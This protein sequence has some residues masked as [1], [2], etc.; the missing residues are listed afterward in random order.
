M[1]PILAD[2]NPYLMDSFMLRLMMQKDPRIKRITSDA[3][4]EKKYSAIIF[5]KDPQSSSEWYSNSH[6]GREFVDMVLRNYRFSFKQD[7]YTVYVPI[8]SNAE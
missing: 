7:R 5:D 8:S 6:F 1:L 4:T 3:I 2:K